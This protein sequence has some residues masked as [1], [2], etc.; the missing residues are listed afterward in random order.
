MR[1]AQKELVTSKINGSVFWNKVFIL[2]SLRSTDDFSVSSTIIRQT[3]SLSAMLTA[4]LSS[5]YHF[6][7]STLKNNIKED[8]N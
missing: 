4:Y 3:S 5:H 1:T 7:R 6:K 2:L 8:G